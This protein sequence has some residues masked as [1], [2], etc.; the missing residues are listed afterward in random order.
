MKPIANKDDF[1]KL[2][3]G[4]YI[5][6][7]SNSKL[8]I[9]KFLWAGDHSFNTANK[10]YIAVQDPFSGSMNGPKALKE[11]HTSKSR[12]FGLF[13]LSEDEILTHVVLPNI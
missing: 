7:Y 1:S 11:L 10:M 6:L 4:S 2:K 12:L 9:R 3:P 5:G 8:V 13:E